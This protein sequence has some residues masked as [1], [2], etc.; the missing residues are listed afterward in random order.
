MAGEA[1]GDNSSPI[2][3][4]ITNHL[5]LLNFCFSMTPGLLK[6]SMGQ[7][8]FIYLDRKNGGIKL[9]VIQGLSPCLS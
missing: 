7:K 1:L 5:V 2:K 9:V 8:G 4:P 6:S 3:A